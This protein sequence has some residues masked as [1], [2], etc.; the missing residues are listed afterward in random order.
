MILQEI[1]DRVMFQTNNDAEDLG[2]YEPFVNG[3]INEGYDL[4][5][6]AYD[7]THV[8]TGTSETNPLKNGE[9][10]PS[11]PDW[12]HKALA[13]WATWCLYRNGNPAKQQR[14]YQFRQ[15][16]E[17]VLNKIRAAGGSAGLTTAVTAFSNV[18]N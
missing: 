8:G 11:T 9:D 2:D 6:E 13:A 10:E 5:M 4:L 3:Y 17:E 18:P 15:E 12:T 1:K 14:G 16:F 7:G